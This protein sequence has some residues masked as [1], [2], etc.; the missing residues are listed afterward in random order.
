MLDALRRF[1]SDLSSPDSAPTAEDEQRIAVAAL[2][3]HLVMADGIVE[4]EEKLALERVLA[5]H[6]ALDAE[7]ARELVREG[8]EREE[9]AVDFYTFTSLLKRSLDETGRREVV[10]MMWEVV[11]ADGA[12][13]EL[14][15]NIIWRVAELLGISTRE[16]VEIKQRI[17]ERGPPVATG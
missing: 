8:R 12:V 15:D 16:R 9:N 6:F 5:E 3:V 17:K 2:L 11:Y 4:G 1:L 7:A 14:E 13:G 10:Q